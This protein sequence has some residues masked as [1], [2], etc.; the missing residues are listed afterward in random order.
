[1]TKKKKIFLL[2]A[3]VCLLIALGVGLVSCMGENG[4]AEQKPV[5]VIPDSGEIMTFT[6]VLTTEGG[7]ALE[8]V[9]VYFY[10]DSTMQELVWF[11]KTD[12]EGKASFTDKASSSYVAVLDNVPAGY[13]VEEYYP[14]LYA[15][16]E[17][18]LSTDM[19]DGDLANITYAL[20]D[21][22][23]NFSVTDV[24]G[25]V[26][27]LSELLQEKQAVVLNFW[28]L[29]CAPCKAEF[30]HLQEAYEKYS[31]KIAVLALNPINDDR[32]GIANYALENGLTFPMAY[33]D[34]AWEQAMQLTAYPTTVIID[35]FGTIALIH[36]GSVD[37]AKV[38][39]DAFEFFSAEDYEQT[40][41]ENIKDLEIQDAGSSS[42]NPIEISGKSSFEVTVAP[43]QLVYY[44]LYKLTK[45]NLSINNQNAYVIYKDKTY[46]PSG[47]SIGFKVTCPDMFTPAQLAFGN[48]GTETVTYT[49]YLAADKGTV[50]NPYS[51]KLGDFTAKTAA[52]NEQG[53]YYTY[54]PQQDG[55][56]TV[57]CNSVSPAGVR[58]GISLTTQKGNATVQRN[59]E[60]DGDSEAGTVSIPV[61][62]GVKVQIILSTLPDDSNT[63]P[64][65]TF[66]CTLS[67]GEDTGDVTEDSE[68][69]TYAVTVTDQDIIPIP[70]V[71]M[72]M[73]AVVAE[74]QEESSTGTTVKPDS[75]TTN[76]RGVAYI[77]KDAGTYEVTISL[78]IGYEG[79]TTQ[80][81]LTTDR[82]YATIKLDEVVVEMKTYTIVVTDVNGAPLA[83]ALITIAGAEPKLTDETGTVT[84]ELPK[85]RHAVS[86]IPP[87]GYVAE[88]EYTMEADSTGLN[89]VL[90]A[91]TAEENPDGGGDGELQYTVTVLDYSG[92]AQSGAVV[93]F[94]QDGSIKATKQTDGNGIVTAHLPAAEYT[95][96]LTFT[97]TAL[98]Y[99]SD[100]AVLPEGITELILRVAPG[101]EK[102]FYEMIYDKYLSYY[103]T[104]GNTYVKLQPN[105]DNY[106][107]FYTK[108]PG[109]YHVTTSD[110]NAKVSH[111]GGST[112]FINEYAPYVDSFDLNVKESY[113]PD[114][115]IGYVA[116]F[117]ITGADDCVIQITR[118]GDAQLD[119]TDIVPEVYK[120]KKAPTAAAGKISAAQ[121]K[122]LTYVDMSGKTS[123]YQIVMGS[124]GYYHLNSAT[125]PLL[126]MNIGPN[127]PFHSLYYMA[128]AGGNGVAGTGIKATVYDENGAVVKRLDFSECMLAYGEC[129]DPTY[130]VYPLTEDLVYMV[131]TAGEYYGWWDST[132]P[133]FWL[134]TVTNLNPE[135]GWMFAV[136]YVP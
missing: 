122:K 40:T 131:Q 63:Y 116:V 83:G 25:K 17:I 52:G 30:P 6:V 44:H 120:P 134:D 15:T 100:K 41:V 135:L 78:P 8:D 19:A 28:Y 54:T 12:A 69:I 5:S 67:I 58:Y 70:N 101:V 84:M 64:A 118:E 66:K 24:D 21:V 129:I 49:V 113:I 93:Q 94:L 23:M 53:V 80:F 87:S 13:K 136:C 117:S 33:C 26:W 89:V 98:Y 121:G 107:I 42:E 46:N 73:K 31:D 119:E 32:E 61:T 50:N 29:Q 59:M 105:I 27:V 14:L 22:M 7:K 108:T 11:A 91:G 43:G 48:S 51:A 110:E 86:I 106:F 36:K 60:E 132:D 37:E 71:V 130:G 45:I 128:G 47:G 127:A 102:D 88:T 16:M 90:E 95:V 79:A 125:G 75:L 56:L 81:C 57:Q 97:G 20:G 3:A 34:P 10:T 82:P 65:A 18:V 103:V 62:K 39:E 115:D 4:N 109:D 2:A 92:K 77:T 112:S 35:R 68:K 104:V 133:D 99:E 74:A 123:D 76:E 55:L 38:F 9:G 114:N 72:A 96:T 85:A 1:M 124:D 111:R 126:Y